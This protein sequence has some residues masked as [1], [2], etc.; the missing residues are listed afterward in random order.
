MAM[1]W[2]KVIRDPIHDIVPFEDNGCDRLLLDL[3]NTLEFQRL[4]RIKQLGMSD[5][6]FPGASHTR[7]SHS[8]G[9]MQVARECLWQLRKHDPEIN[10]ELATLVLVAALLHDLGHAPFSHAFEKITGREHE[11]WTAEIIADQHT[12]VGQRLRKFDRQLPNRL[13]RLLDFKTGESQLQKLGIPPYLRQIVSSQLD[14]DRFDYLLRDAHATGTK[15]GEFDLSWLLL[16]LRPEARKNRL[17]LDRKALYAA[18]SYVFA[19]YH[20]YRV[21]YFHK[22][23]RAAEVML[24]LLFRRFTELLDGRTGPKSVR[25]I[26]PNCPS[27]LSPFPDTVGGFLDLDDATVT[28]FFRSC[29]S[30]ADP[31]LS[32][33]GAG[34]IERRLYKAIDVTGFNSSA[35][36]DLQEAVGEVIRKARLE[37][38][39]AWV[40]DSPADTPYKPYDPDEEVPAKQIYVEDSAGGIREIAALSPAVQTL[41]QRFTLE[42][43]YFPE[44][45][46][47]RVTALAQEKLTEK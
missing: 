39:Y 9:V 46:R 5:M 3:V 29:R 13:I 44:Q 10:D 42:R 45:I 19:R 28:E 26:V 4:R 34:L 41:R 11:V 40:S 30:S 12:Q 37:K 8:I 6:V 36:A 47:G 43:Y 25:R 38:D 35:I 16:H 23:T 14:A 24:G 22:A 2:P 31:V 32:A 21:V 33:L 27:A 7:F 15:Y 18:E 20:M 17:Y 1:S